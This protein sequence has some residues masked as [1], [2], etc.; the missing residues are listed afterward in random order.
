MMSW[1]ANSFQV[2]YFEPLCLWTLNLADLPKNECTSAYQFVDDW[3]PKAYQTAFMMKSKDG[4]EIGVAT[5]DYTPP[6]V[7]TVTQS[8][9]DEFDLD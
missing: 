4:Q 2:G 9:D 8:F 6:Y 5:L 1:V 3:K 7:K